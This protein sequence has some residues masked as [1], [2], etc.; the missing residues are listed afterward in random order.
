MNSND[1][2]ALFTL[3]PIEGLVA[4][5]V[6]RMSHFDNAKFTVNVVSTCHPA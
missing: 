2:E 3:F 4:E 6:V 5:H 1:G